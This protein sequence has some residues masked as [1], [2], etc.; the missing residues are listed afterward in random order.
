MMQKSVQL[1]LIVL[2]VQ[3]Y[4]FYVSLDRIKLILDNQVAQLVMLEVSVKTL[5]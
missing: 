2:L 1:V 5:E 4:H 3:V